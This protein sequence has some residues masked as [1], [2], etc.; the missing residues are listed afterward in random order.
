METFVVSATT[1]FFAELNALLI[2]LQGV[3]VTSTLVAYGRVT[4]NPGDY[5]VIQ[6]R[7]LQLEVRLPLVGPIECALANRLPDQVHITVVQ[8]VSPPGPGYTTSGFARFAD[9]IFL[10]FLVSYHE[11][12]RAEIESKFR[13]GRTSWPSPW[14]MSWALRNAVSHDG[15]VFEKHTQRAVHWRGLTFSP[16]DEPA[17]QLLQLVNGADMLV[18]ML[19]MEEARAGRP[20]PRA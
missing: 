13:Q 4:H 17:K 20:L 8:A 14:Q 3:S 16:S 12:H 10:P 15:R 18:L 2:A 7:H 11:R 9:A 6:G 1:G 19:E 5:V